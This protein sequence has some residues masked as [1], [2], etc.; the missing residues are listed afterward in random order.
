MRSSFLNVFCSHCRQIY[1]LQR[2]RFKNAYIAHCVLEEYY[3]SSRGHSE[4]VEGKDEE[5]ESDSSTIDR[6]ATCTSTTTTT[7]TRTTTR[8]ETTTTSTTHPLPYTPPDI[9]HHPRESNLP[10]IILH[11]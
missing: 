1:R 6:G 9:F 2:R 3:Y 4:V 8:E 10:I 5:R 7:T 11:E